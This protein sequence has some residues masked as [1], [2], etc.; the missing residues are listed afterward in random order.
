MRAF[1]R[2]LAI[3][4]SVLVLMAGSGGWYVFVWRPA[5]PTVPLV[6]TIEEGS[7]LRAA[8]GE[9]RSAGALGWAEPLVVL[10]RLTGAHTKV[11][12]GQY[13]LQAGLSLWELLHKITRGDVTLSEI[14]FVE[15]WSLRDWRAARS[16]HADL[17]HDSAAVSDADLA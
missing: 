13:E 1:A 7:G 6:F 3:G 8:A 4:L 5:L 2:L 15:G 16:A 17:R 11:R 14:T 12:A 9:M 10:G